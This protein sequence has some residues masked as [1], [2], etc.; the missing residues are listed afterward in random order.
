[1]KSSKLTNGSM[2]ENGTHN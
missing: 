2:R 1:M